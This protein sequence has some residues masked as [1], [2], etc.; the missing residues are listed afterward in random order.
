MPNFRKK[1]QCWTVCIRCWRMRNHICL[2][3]GFHSDPW[4]DVIIRCHCLQKS[5][6]SQEHSWYS[7]VPKSMT[8]RLCSQSNETCVFPWPPG[9]WGGQIHDPG[10]MNFTKLRVQ[11]SARIGVHSFQKTK[12]LEDPAKPAAKLKQVI[13]VFYKMNRIKV[14]I[15]H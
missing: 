4:N 6:S 3:P 12:T 15:L 13:I 14:T 7:I 1:L 10:A 2:P 9:G 5:I 11:S 8:P